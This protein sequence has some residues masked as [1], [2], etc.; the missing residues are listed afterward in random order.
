MKELTIWG[1]HGGKT[2]D[3]D[4]LFLK[5]NLIG[6]GWTKIGDL[7][8]L[9]PDRDAF[10]AEVVTNQASFMANEVSVVIKE[11]SGMTACTPK[12]IKKATFTSFAASTGQNATAFQ[13][14]GMN[15]TG[16]LSFAA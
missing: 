4:S 7:S 2:G 9:K 3:A 6:V 16:I 1:I 14:S 5:K 8:K 15:F 13:S 12:T 10:K 11:A